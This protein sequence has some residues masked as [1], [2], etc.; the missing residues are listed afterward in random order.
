MLAG[1]AGQRQRDISSL[2]GAFRDM[3]L[4]LGRG[5]HM[6]RIT[7]ACEESEVETAK[8][9]VKLEVDVND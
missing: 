1:T 2:K 4:S 9:R 3:A 5:S 6:Y 7:Q 8:S